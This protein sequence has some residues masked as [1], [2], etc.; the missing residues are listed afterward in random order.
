MKPER[1]TL[2]AALRRRLAAHRSTCRPDGGRL[3]TAPRGPGD[4]REYPQVVPRE[5]GRQ[6]S[7]KRYAC[8]DPV[9]AID[10]SQS[11][12]RLTKVSKIR[13]SR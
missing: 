11:H 2:D 10:L 3:R 8:A 7:G 12:E 9:L 5:S 13:I 4:R 1:C 6:K